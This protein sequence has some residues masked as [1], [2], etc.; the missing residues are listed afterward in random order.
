MS[1]IRAFVTRH[2]VPSYFVLTFAISWG[3]ALLV[4]GGSGSMTGTAPSDDPRFAFAVMAMLV[5]PS[6]AGILLTGLIHGRAGLRAF[7]SR[8]LAWRVGV[9]WYAAALLI[10]PLLMLATLFALS[11]TSPAFLPGIVVSADKASLLL[12]SLAVGL[13]AGIFE[14]LGWTGFAIPELRRRHGV[15]ATGLIVGVVWSAWHL[16]PNVWSASMAAGELSVATYL[17]TNLLGVLVGYLTAFRVLM[18]W[19]YDSTRSL[20]V[21]ML[22]HLSFT[23]SLLILNPLGISGAALVTYSFALAAA[24]WIVVGAVGLATHGRLTR[25][26]VRTRVA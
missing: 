8:L 26:S 2:A 13:G 12:I 9:R 18:V 17:S 16:L 1:T 19:V 25:Q 11:L 20:F 21:G 15:L 24:I 4:I 6:V 3:S 14:E 5:G 22:M 10:A 7:Q 23:A